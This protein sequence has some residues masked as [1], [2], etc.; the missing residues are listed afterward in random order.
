MLAQWLPWMTIG[1][2]HD[3]SREAALQCASPAYLPVPAARAINYAGRECSA[4]GHDP[5][6][7][8]WKPSCVEEPDILAD[9]CHTYKTTDAINQRL[10]SMVRILLIL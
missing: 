4:M 9:E 1:R 10:S 3:L 6:Y 2:L 7:V 5:A 8:P